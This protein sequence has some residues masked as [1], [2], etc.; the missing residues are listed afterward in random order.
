MAQL[1]VQ[2]RMRRP[3][4]AAC[5][6]PVPRRDCRMSVADPRFPT[7]HWTKIDAIRRGN[8]REAA[9]ALEEI[10]RDYWYPI[11]AFLRRNGLDLHDA[12]DAAQGFFQRL[13]SDN[14]LAEA[15]RERG[16]LRS[17][18]LGALKR[19]RIDD[20]RR[21]HARKRGG[22]EAL[23]SI[24]SS[25][26]ERLYQTRFSH[27]DD[28]EAIYLRSWAES[29][30]QKVKA[31]LREEFTSR[32]RAA[33]FEALEPHLVDEESAP[34]YA[35]L[36]RRLGSTPGAVRLLVFRL[37]R[38]FRERLEGAVAKTL[39]DPAEFDEE[40]AWLRRTLVSVEG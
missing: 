30:L 3:G 1:R 22:G 12:Q 14:T 32:G 25:E 33:L 4:H 40:M 18:L 31:G 37:R 9:A 16:R 35:E 11:Y 29:L 21:D 26:A 23:V 36:A 2:N 28:A 20:Y 27:H 6:K 7:T 19:V 39:L 38:N 8:A 13:V 34:P 10:C 17:F 5:V 15:R 24:E